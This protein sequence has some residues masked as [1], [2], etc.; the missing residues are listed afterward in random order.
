M[1]GSQE[2]SRTGDRELND[3]STPFSK[4]GLQLMFFESKLTLKDSQRE[5]A[6][7]T[8]VTLN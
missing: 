6:D 5:F 1:A 7:M 3:V 4:L 8:Q 2:M